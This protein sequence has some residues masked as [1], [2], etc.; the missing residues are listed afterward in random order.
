M[1]HTET[2]L[3]YAR[4]VLPIVATML[5][6]GGVMRA[7]SASS[8]ATSAE[9]LLG[10]VFGL[11][12]IFTDTGAARLQGHRQGLALNLPAGTDPEDLVEV[13]KLAGLGGL[14]GVLKRVA[15][16][17]AT[18]AEIIK[19]VPRVGPVV[20][21]ITGRRQDANGDPTTPELVGAINALGEELAESRRAQGAALEA[22]R[23]RISDLETRADRIRD[24]VATHTSRLD[25]HALRANTLERRLDDVAAAVN[26]LTTPAPAARRASRKKAS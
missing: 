18:Y 13:A 14:G 24:A 3:R 15:T 1:K 4:M 8:F 21:K 20:E 19:N 10:G 16:D 6:S 12:A 25:S 23:A 17:P 7:E 9:A 26:K 2:I 5:I 22:E 11:L